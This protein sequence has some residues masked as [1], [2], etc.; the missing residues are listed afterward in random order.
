MIPV[1]A[2]RLERY[3]AV[4]L[5]RQAFLNGEIFYDGSNNTLRLF[6]GKTAGGRSLATQNWTTTNFASLAAVTT[7]NATIN[8]AIALKAPIASPTFTG[9]VTGTFSG[10]ITGAVTGNVTGNADTATKLAATKNI[11]NVAFDGS[12][13]ITL[14]TL[15]NGSNT[16]TLGSNGTTTFPTNISINYSGGNVQF[17]RII[18]D[19]GKAFSVQ[20]Q[21]ASGSAALAWT[22]DPDAA[23]QYAQIGVTKNGGDNL[24]KVI[25]TAQSDSSDAETA[26]IWKFD[27]A[28]VMTAP[29]NITTTTGTVTASA[30]TITTAVTVGTNVNISTVPTLPQHATN[31]KYVDAR[32][33]AMSIAMS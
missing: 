16:I 20:G 15:V 2:L 29:G 11:N 6:D 31:K 26:K 19:S 9:T 24:A 1:R 8:S 28:G 23:G 22:V 25:L 18:A 4:S 13:N 3:D 33:L 32:A 10:N 14:S 17:P 7:N 27:E 12:T 30:A 21:G 5:E